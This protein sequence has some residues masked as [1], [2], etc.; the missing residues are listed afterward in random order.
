[1]FLQNIKEKAVQIRD[2]EIG[3]LIDRQFVTLSTCSYEFENAR[4]VLI[5]YLESQTR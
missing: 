3:E 2:F 5:G 4:T 1:M